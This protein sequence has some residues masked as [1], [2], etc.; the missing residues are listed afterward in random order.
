[1]AASFRDLSCPRFIPEQHRRVFFTALFIGLLFQGLVA[2]KKAVSERDFVGKWQS[3]RAVT[4]IYLADNGEWEIR[5]DDGT[6]LQY[7]LWRYEDKK[8]IWS[9][10]QDGRL[11]DDPNPVLAVTPEAFSLKELDGSTTDFRKVR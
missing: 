5:K 1:M 11:M 9:V 7:G 4:P 6:V 2:C 10:K 8:I 3:S